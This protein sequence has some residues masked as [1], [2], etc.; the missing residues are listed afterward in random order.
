MTF[1]RRHAVLRGGIVVVASGLLLA[2]C[3]NKDESK[4]YDACLA[5]G[6]D[7]YPSAKFES[8]G[9]SAITKASDASY[10]VRISYMLDGTPG[11]LECALAKQGD[12]NFANA[13]PPVDTTVVPTPVTPPASDTTTPVNPSTTD[14]TT[15][16]PAP[17]PGTPAD[18]TTKP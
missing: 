11:T 5:I 18:T 14:T 6:K 4:A 9:K 16:T 12:G 8:K 13:A 2:A 17:V 1:I 3:G 7:R 10:T 15:P